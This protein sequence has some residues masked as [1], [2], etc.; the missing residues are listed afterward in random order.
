ML[1]YRH[2]IQS[3]ITRTKHKI[4]YGLSD[5]IEVNAGV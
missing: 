5:L 2:F 3:P 1:L 4:L